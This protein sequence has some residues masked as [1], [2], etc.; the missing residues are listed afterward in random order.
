VYQNITVAAGRHSNE[1]IELITT[2]GLVP[3]L[4]LST[5][6]MILKVIVII[7]YYHCLPCIIIIIIIIIIISI[8]TSLQDFRCFQVLNKRVVLI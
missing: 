2:I 7:R 4:L 3:V 1:G 6:V 5:V 8:I